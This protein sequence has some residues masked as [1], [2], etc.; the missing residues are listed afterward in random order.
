[1]IPVTRRRMLHSFRLETFLEN[2]KLSP[3]SNDCLANRRWVEHFQQITFPDFK[4][5]LP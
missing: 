3:W 1:M 5:T 4:E 2:F